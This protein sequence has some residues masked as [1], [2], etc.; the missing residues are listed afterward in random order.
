M[1][2]LCVEGNLCENS[3][4]TEV[5]L[6]MKKMRATQVAEQNRRRRRKKNVQFDTVE[7]LLSQG[8]SM[9]AGLLLPPLFS[10]PPLS[11]PLSPLFPPCLP[12]SSSGLGLD[13]AA[14]D[15]KFTQP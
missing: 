3:R 10:F 5:E 4:P 12:F 6:K 9:Q 11:P 8:R 14:P 7:Y 2:K 13:P 1:L 15:Q